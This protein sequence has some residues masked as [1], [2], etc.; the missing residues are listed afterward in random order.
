MSILPKMGILV[1]ALRGKRPYLLIPSERVQSDLTRANMVQTS[2]D[3]SQ[4]LCHSYILL[5]CVPLLHQYTVPLDLTNK[6]IDTLISCRNIFLWAKQTVPHEATFIIVQANLSC[7]LLT[8]PANQHGTRT[9]GPQNGDCS[10][11]DCSSFLPSARLTCRYVVLLQ[12]TCH[13][14]T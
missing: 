8:P 10:Q 1:M 3:C 7:H 14:F 13:F 4:A 12:K 6:S 2:H 5:Y 9:G 11:H